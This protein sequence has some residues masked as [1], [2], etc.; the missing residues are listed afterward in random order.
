[1]TLDMYRSLVTVSFRHYDIHKDQVRPRFKRFVQRFLAAGGDYDGVPN[2]GKHS[3]QQLDN[4]WLIVY[5]QYLRTG[6][7]TTLT[8]H[9]PLPFGC[10]LMNCGCL[11]FLSVIVIYLPEYKPWI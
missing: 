11:P 4:E 2:P 9:F 7:F 8:E 1:M 5:H 3:L 6:F 10:R